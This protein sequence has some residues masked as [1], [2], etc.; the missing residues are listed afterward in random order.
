MRAILFTRDYNFSFDSFNGFVL[1]EFVIA[2]V[3]A[4]LPVCATCVYACR[5]FRAYVI[6]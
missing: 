3:H 4:C 5:Q 1:I 6:K 2:C